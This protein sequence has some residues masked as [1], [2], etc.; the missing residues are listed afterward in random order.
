MVHVNLCCVRPD[1]KRPN[2][3]LSLQ[4]S[5]GFPGID[6]RW[7]IFSGFSWL[8]PMSACSIVAVSL[9]YICSVPAVQ[10]FT[11]TRQTCSAW[12]IPFKQYAGVCQENL[13]STMDFALKY[14]LKCSEVVFEVQRSAYFAVLG[15]HCRRTWDSRVMTLDELKVFGTSLVVTCIS[16]FPP[17]S[18]WGDRE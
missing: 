3:K 10:Y 5:S 18:W 13:K 12:G 8:F 9:Q 6:S 1:L 15:L 16:T 7:F 4:G 14:P 11:C 17:S 2:S